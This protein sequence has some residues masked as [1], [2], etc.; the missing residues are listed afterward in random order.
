MNV[1]YAPLTRDI[2]FRNR[3]V[4]LLTN[5]H[6]PI[7]KIIPKFYCMLELLNNFFLEYD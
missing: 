3:L 4:K 2:I 5:L 1:M 6:P 7:W